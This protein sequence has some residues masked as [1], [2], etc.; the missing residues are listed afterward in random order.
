MMP[1]NP[2]HLNESESNRSG[3]L[4]R[5]VQI[6][7]ANALTLEDIAGAL[8]LEKNTPEKSPAILNR[9]FVY[10]GG[11]FLFAGLC[12]LA[13]VLW[14]D[15]TSLQRI[16]VSFGSGLISMALGVLALRDLRFEKASTPFF[17]IS[18]A[19]QPTGLF[20]FLNEY[21]PDG[22]DPQLAALWIFG[23]MALQHILIFWKTQKTS[24]LFCALAFGYSAAGLFLDRLDVPED[25]GIF[26]LGVSMLCVGYAVDRTPH[27]VIVPFGYAIAMAATLY[28][29]FDIVENT[30]LEITYLGLNAF[31]IYLSIHLSS[32]TVLFVSVAGLLGYI[33]WYTSEH[34]AGVVGWPIALIILGFVFLGLGALTIRLSHRIPST[35]RGR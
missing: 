27:R 24:L 13:G 16:I 19:L 23:I 9:L 3:A 26:V 22:G 18:A 7:R 11:I 4:S 5:I 17:L 12:A 33:A 10:L 28:G 15:M 8:A 29:F 21:F 20:V 2:D 35:Q 25:I 31:L 32:R 1:D 30:P 14:D 6:A 34:F